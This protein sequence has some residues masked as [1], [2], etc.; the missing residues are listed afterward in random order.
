MNVSYFWQKLLTRIRLRESEKE[1][2]NSKKFAF[3]IHPRISAREDIGKVFPLFKFIPEKLLRK[4]IVFF[5]PIVRGKVIFIP[6]RKLIGWIIVIPLTGEQLLSFPREFVL[7]KL[8][9]ALRKAKK[10]G[11]E[12]IGLGE[13]L[14]SITKGGEELVGKVP[15]ILID[16]G[17]ALT[18]GVTF[19]AIEEIAKVKG[20]DLS[21]TKIAIVGGAGSI[22][23]TVGFL[24]SEK[25][26]FL[27]LVDKKGKVEELEKVFGFYKNKLITHNLER[28]KE[29][30]IVIV[31]TASTQQIV[32]SQFLGENTIVYDITQPRNTSPRILKE[33]KDITIIDGGVLDTPLFDYGMDI[34]LKKHQAYACLAEAM[35]CAMEKLNKNFVGYPRLEDAKEMIS[36]FDKHS[37][38]FRLNIF[39]SFGRPI[40]K[41]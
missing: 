30:K 8:I 38:Y 9:Q 32:S 3:L 6:N 17:K 36:F 40:N 26:S 1:N 27:I 15:G 4:L 12:I 18:A 14:A 16:N 13:F 31:A 25:N 21:K 10:L 2:S 34:G 20:I 5:P 28:I 11:V 29:A 19:K 35:I 24:F 39:Q 7:K 41:I 37:E 33:R 22:G 23:R